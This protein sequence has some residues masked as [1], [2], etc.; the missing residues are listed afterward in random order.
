MLTQASASPT[1]LAALAKRIKPGEWAEL[2][3][4]NFSRSLLETP[5]SFIT[6]F[7]D[8]AVWNPRTQEVYF[9]G[10]GHGDQS[11]GLQTR[12][13]KYSAAAN[14]WSVTKVPGAL[15]EIIHTYDHNAINPANGEFYHRKFNSRE[16]QRYDPAS[17]S[18]SALPQWPSGYTTSITGGLDYFPELGGLVYINGCGKDNNEGYALLFK[19]NKWSELT[20]GLH[21]G[22]YHTFIEYNPVQ[23]VAVFGGGEWYNQGESREMYKLDAQGK[24]AK[25]KDAPL[26][27][28]TGETVFTVDPVSGKYLVFGRDRSFWEYNVMAEK[29]T[30]LATP[31]PFFNETSRDNPV[32]GTIATPVADYGVIFFLS[33]YVGKVY[34]YKH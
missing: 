34:L 15:Y 14:A 12:F 5:G 21:F 27:L 23:R 28:G 16:V 26:D 9:L 4:A 1:E 24:I 31:V 18:W 11:A 30:K 17:A 29:W 3:T 13:L 19:D 8:D 33:Y 2:K 32:Q 20:S 25:L 22:D 6:A 7:S 10:A